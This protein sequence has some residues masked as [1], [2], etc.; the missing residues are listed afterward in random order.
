MSLYHFNIIRFVCS[1]DI[2]LEVTTLGLGLFDDGSSQSVHIH[3]Q[4]TSLTDDSHVLH[5]Y[6]QINHDFTCLIQQAAMCSSYAIK[7]QALR[8]NTRI[9]PLLHVS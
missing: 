8:G 1:E 9:A 7:Q 2:V 5:R 6:D 3:Y 4:T